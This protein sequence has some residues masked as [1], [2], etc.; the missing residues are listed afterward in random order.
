MYVSLFSE[1]GN[2][3]KVNMHCHTNISD[4]GNTPEEIKEAYVE[5]GYSAVCFTDH[6]VLVSHKDL[7]DER[8]V[9][10]HG[11]EVS[12]SDNRREYPNTGY[13]PV[14]HVNFIAKSQDNLKMPRFFKNNPTKFGNAR[15]WANEIGQYDEND[16]IDCIKY[17]VEWLNDYFGA[18]SAAGFLIN[19]NHPQW[20]L[21]TRED[22][23]GLEHIHSVEIVNGTCAP[24]NDNTS[25]PY[26]HFLRVGKRVAPTG[27]DDNHGRANMF[28][29]WTVIKANELTY[30]ALISAY[31]RGDCYASEGPDIYSISIEDGIIKVKTSPVRA[32]VLMCDTRFSRKKLSRTETYTEAEFEYLPEKFGAYFRIELKDAEGCKAFSNAFYVDDINKIIDSEK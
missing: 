1:E 19:Y 20:S 5:A 16:T 11:Y 2:L 26:E 8:F 10:L 22:Y 24:T 29:G 31:E 4:G 6:E 32:I 12:I 9:A 25:I 15:M 28:W 14:Y 18:V 13:K 27:G 23:I 30:D 3:Y 7:C 17:D 21:Q